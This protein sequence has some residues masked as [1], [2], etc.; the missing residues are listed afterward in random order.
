MNVPVLIGAALLGLVLLAVQLADRRVRHAARPRAESAH[1]AKG[2]ELCE[3]RVEGP[4]KSRIVLGRHG[5]HLL[6]AEPQ[7]SVI[8]FGPTR[9]SFKTSSLAIPAVRDWDGPVIATSVKSDLL[10]ATLEQRRER[11]KVMIFDPLGVTG[12]ESVRAS[13]LTSCRTWPGSVRMAHWLAI[14]AATAARDLTDADFWHRAAEKL[15]APLLFAAATSSGEMADVIRWLNEGEAA[16]GEV[17]SCIAATAEPEPLSAW[18]ANL[19]RDERQRS[20]INTTAETILSAF[21]DPLVLANSARPDYLPADLLAGNADTLYLCAP[22]HEQ[23]R[24]SALFAMMITELLAMVDVSAIASGHPLDPAL[25][26]VLDEAANIAPVPHLDQIAATGAG[27]GVQ[28]L[29]VFHDLS[30]IQSCYGK[31]ALSIVNNHVAKVFG[32]GIGDPPTLEYVRQVTGSTEVSQHSETA[33]EGR[34]SSTEGSTHRD[35]APAHVVRAIAPK[36]AILVYAHLA[37]ARLQLL[38][39][40]EEESR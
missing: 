30:Q 11:G 5:R 7:S 18:T 16:D 23:E 9:K 40:F 14:S 29:S 19:K 6:A 38:P 25:L 4:Q 8:A 34:R 32:A 26:V 21:A 17:G 22:R 37:A 33:G 28:L 20:S 10:H 31:L 36:R 12:Y 3:L 1:W 39:W 35:L 2:R 24:L 27:Q 15:L 13:P